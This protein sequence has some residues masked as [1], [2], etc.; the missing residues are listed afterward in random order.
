M[1]PVSIPKATELLE[2]LWTNMQRHNRLIKV[3]K[4]IEKQQAAVVARFLSLRRKRRR[5]SRSGQE[6]NPR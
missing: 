4:R 6:E 1:F 2:G 3:C 5:K